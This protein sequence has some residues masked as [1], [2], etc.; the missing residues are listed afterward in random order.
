MTF[1]NI[2]A[3]Y[4][5]CLVTVHNFS[6]VAVGHAVP[7]CQHTAPAW[8]AVRYTRSGGKKKS[9]VK[10]NKKAEKILGLL[11][12]PLA[13]NF[14]A[15]GHPIVLLLKAKVDRFPWCNILSFE[16]M[17]KARL[18]IH[19]MKNLILLMS[20]FNSIYFCLG[21]FSALKLLS[22]LNMFNL[23]FKRM[24]KEDKLKENIL[25]YLLSSLFLKYFHVTFCFALE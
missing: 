4:P 22:F 25:P 6:P 12:W 10:E 7:G 24:E 17:L 23:I 3:I 13:H 21:I 15:A 20:W 18:N 11:H 19:V 5:F 1:L 2:F 14:P 9:A 16:N 8:F